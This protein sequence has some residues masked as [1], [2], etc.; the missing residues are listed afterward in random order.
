MATPQPYH[1]RIMVRTRFL[2]DQSAPD[3]NRFVFSYTIRIVNEGSVAARLMSRH[4]VI[5][6]S[7]GHVQEVRGDG[8]VGEQPLLKPGQDFEYTS[9][10]VLETAIGTMRGSYQMLAEDGC[11]FDADIAQFTLSVP[12]TVH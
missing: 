12:R 2:D 3:S 4:W 8:V 9:G 10:A 5:T 11:N 1:I 7:N 6:D